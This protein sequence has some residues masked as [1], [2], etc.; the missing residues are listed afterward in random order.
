M[1]LSSRSRAVVR[2][3]TG[4]PPWRG[5]RG[6]VPAGFLRHNVCAARKRHV[7]TEPG[8][9]LRNVQHQPALALVVAR[10]P[11]ATRASRA[12]VANFDFIV[13]G[14]SMCWR[15]QIGSL[16]Q[17]DDARCET[18]SKRDRKFKRCALDHSPPFTYSP[19]RQAPKSG[20]A[21]HRRVF[22]HPTMASL[23]LTPS[24]AAAAVPRSG[25]RSA[26]RPSATGRRRRTSRSNGRR[27]R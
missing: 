14:L 20:W 10:A 9:I 17:F 22:A 16:G 2:T 26:R 5:G 11:V 7:V 13:I 18:G 21:R 3:G 4:R 25:S 24:R 27:D 12:V 19:G 1:A 15:N 8:R 23:R 6:L